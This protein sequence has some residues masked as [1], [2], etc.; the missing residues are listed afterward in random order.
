MIGL[1]GAGHMGSSLGAVLRRG[2]HE[3]ATSLAGRSRR[4][5][6][7]VGEAG[8]TVLPHLADVL[9]RAEVVLV[10]TPPGAARD[11]ARSIAVAATATGARPLIA[12]LNATSPATVADLVGILAEAG[13][14]LVDGS[15][16]GPPPL[17]KP[18]ARIYLSGPRATEV[19]ALSW[20]DVTPIVVAGPAGA[21]SAVKMSTA[22][23]YKGLMGLLAQAMA[24]AEH[25]GVLDTVMADLG[26]EFG[27]PPDVARAATK[28]HRYVAEMREIAS[29]QAAAGLSGSLF[30]GFAEVYAA[31][32]RSELAAG[33]PE[34][35]S[36]KLTATEVARGLRVSD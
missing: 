17:V 15:I 4:T 10:V 21:A 36:G 31:I 33:D 14:D 7:L 8:I 16:S 13:L 20:R 23:V 27:T 9:E 19:A 22:S 1:V 28:A 35:V 6:G 34:N 3:V 32:A 30:E 29:A 26:G 18:G 12:D 5:A 25:Y 24:S 2:G 11:A